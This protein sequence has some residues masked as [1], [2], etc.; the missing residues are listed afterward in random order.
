MLDIIKRYQNNDYSDKKVTEDELFKAAQDIGSNKELGGDG[1]DDVVNLVGMAKDAV[2]GKDASQFAKQLRWS[3]N[4]PETQAR[5]FM[6]LME[7]VPNISD[8]A[9]YIKQLEESNMFSNGFWKELENLK[10]ESA[11]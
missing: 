6:K 1:S 10:K 8:R 9:K 4:S 11:E 2:R 5:I 7:K 3:D